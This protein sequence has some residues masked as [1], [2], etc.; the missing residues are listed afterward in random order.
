MSCQKNLVKRFRNELPKSPPNVKMLN[1]KGVF[2]VRNKRKGY[3]K[4]NF[5]KFFILRILTGKKHRQIKLQRLQ[6]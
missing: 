2:L 6:K 4:C 1:K 5:F 3:V